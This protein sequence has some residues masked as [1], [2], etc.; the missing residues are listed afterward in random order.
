M[1]A[2]AVD[3]KKWL[4]IFGSPIPFHATSLS[5]S[6]TTIPKT[7][8]HWNG[9]LRELRSFRST[10]MYRF[11]EDTCRNSF[12]A[13][14]LFVALLSSLLFSPQFHHRCC[15][16]RRHRRLIVN[17]CCFLSI[18][19]SSSCIHCQLLILFHVYGRIVFSASVFTIRFTFHTPTL[20]LNSFGL[21]TS[22]HTIFKNGKHKQ[23]SSDW[24]DV[25][26]IC[27]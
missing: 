6:L 19:I 23:S 15:C 26:S 4:V 27:K 1:H 3:A 8:C 5:L 14:F 25:K 13:K 12:A 2:F 10:E 22:A 18:P 21:S 11:S 16:S 17:C 20:L 9:W 24:N 7:H